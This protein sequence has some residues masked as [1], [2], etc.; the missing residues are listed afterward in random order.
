M[1]LKEALNEGIAIAHS[2]K[3]PLADSAAIKIF[4]SK[5]VHHVVHEATVISCCLFVCTDLTPP[6]P[7]TTAPTFGLPQDF[8]DVVSRAPL[9]RPHFKSCAGHDSFPAH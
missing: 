2:S 4:A 9:W 5:A 8:W 7:M 6:P 1:S 3:P